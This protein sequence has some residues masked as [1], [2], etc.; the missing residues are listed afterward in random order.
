MELKLH[1]GT[2][3]TGTTTFQAF[4]NENRDELLNSG[5]LVPRSIGVGNNRALVSCAMGNSNFDDYHSANQIFNLE[6]KKSHDKNIIELLKSE[7]AACSNVH[8]VI[9]SSEHFHSRLV[10]IDE[11]ETLYGILKE[12]FTSIK[13]YVYLRP[14]IEVATSLYSTVLRAGSKL[15]FTD[16]IQSNLRIDNRYYRYDILL[17]EWGTVFGDENIY[18]R[19]FSRSSFV[20]GDLIDDFIQQLGLS[21][22]RQLKRVSNAN[23][24]LNLMGQEFYRASNI[25]HESTARKPY[26]LLEGYFTGKG[27]MPSKE[28]AES[29]QIAFEEYNQSLFSKWFDNNES[30]MVDFAKYGTGN[31]LSASEEALISELFFKPNRLNE[32]DI[33]YLRD[34][35]VKLEKQDINDSLKLMKIAHQYRPDGKFISKKIEKY[36]EL[37]K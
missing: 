1:I 24:S 5:Y 16:F 35:A 3:K 13:V 31:R 29:L 30:F 7:V 22:I 4:L 23:E 11:I 8:T 36:N 27:A 14:Q 25:S 28:L 17:N 10:E 33:D 21:H 6:Q 37:L 26:H 15:K 18:P 12:L 20:N 19:I 34:L 32:K 9:I 2:E